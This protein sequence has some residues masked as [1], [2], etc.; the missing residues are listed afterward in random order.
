MTRI[1]RTALP[2]AAVLTMLLT[3]LIGRD[4]PPQ[5]TRYG[6]PSV[7]ASPMTITRNDATSFAGSGSAAGL[8]YRVEGRVSKRGAIQLRIRV[9]ALRLDAAIDEPGRWITIH[10]A[11]AVLTDR[12]RQAL[13]TIAAQCAPHTA[14]GAMNGGSSL[15]AYIQRFA[16][17]SA[18]APAG[19]RFTHFRAGGPSPASVGDS[20]SLPGWTLY[21]DTAR[22]SKNDGITCISRGAAGAADY[23]D[24]RGCHHDPVVV[25]STARK[26]Y[27][28][29]G[30][31]GPGCGRDGSGAWT[32]DCLDHDQCSHINRSTRGMV[33]PNCGD[34]F[35]QAADDWFFGTLAGCKG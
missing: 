25:G 32:K 33:D 14:A 17:Y 5:P 15:P 35:R 7:S 27:E 8:R 3:A 30:R 12:Q 31:C 1:Q 34:E 23:D 11:G 13:E 22:C 6:Q 21:A 10:G 20:I 9:A 19:F 4:G 18:Q 24:D 26:G 29:M 16:A 2:L 28:C